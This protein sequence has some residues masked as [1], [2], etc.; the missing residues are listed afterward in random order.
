MSGVRSPYSAYEDGQP[1]VGSVLVPSIIGKTD[2]YFYLVK[3]NVIADT[4]LPK[5]VLAHQL[6]T[7]TVLY[8][9]VSTE[10]LGHQEQ[11][12]QAA[13]SKFVQGSESSDIAIATG[14]VL[15][16]Y[17]IGTSVASSDHSVQVLNLPKQ[18]SQSAFGALEELRAFARAREIDNLI[19]KVRDVLPA[20]FTSRLVSRLELLAGEPDEPDEQSMAP[21][22]LRNFMDFLSKFLREVPNLVYPDVVLS[23]SGNIG[24]QWRKSQNEQFSAEFLPSGDVRFLVFTPNPKHQDKVIRASITTSVDLLLDTIKHFVALERYQHG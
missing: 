8:Y 11:S 13:F 22:S 6:G 12:S 5:T 9:N 10:L 7:I 24:V 2:P 23:F 18:P 4:M 17:E 3:E 14:S 1:I 21:G 19:Y 16:I 20:P 15:R